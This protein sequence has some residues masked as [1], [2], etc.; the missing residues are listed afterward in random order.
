VSGY[1][2]TV[3]VAGHRIVVTHS[4]YPDLTEEM[5][6]APHLDDVMNEFIIVGKLAF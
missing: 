2:Q 5:E 3:A 1:L 4:H 6:A